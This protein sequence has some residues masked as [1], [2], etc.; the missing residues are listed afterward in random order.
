MRVSEKEGESGGERETYRIRKLVEDEAGHADNRVH[1][2]SIVVM[3]ICVDPAFIF[4]RH[5]QACISV[6]RAG[7]LVVVDMTK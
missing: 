1:W 7:P 5:C 6:N 4:S 3:I 2:C